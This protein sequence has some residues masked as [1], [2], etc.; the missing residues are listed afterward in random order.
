LIAAMPVLRVWLAL[1][2]LGL[3]GLAVPALAHL[4]PNSEVRLTFARDAVLGEAAIPQGDYAAASGQPVG[5]QP[6]TIAAARRY[7]QPRIGAVSPD[8]A[9]WR[10][11]IDS[12]RFARIA[13]PPDLL[14]RFRLV[15]PAGHSARR[16]VFEWRAVIDSNPSHFALIVLAGDFAAGK[17]DAEPQILGSVQAGERSVA[18]DR[19]DSGLW[20]GFAAAFATGMHHIGNGYDHMLFLLVLL[21]P[22]PV[23]AAAGRWQG[24]RGTMPLA[25]SLL[26][27]VTAF[28]IGHSL[29]LIAAAAFG[30]QLPQRPVEVLIALS[31]AIAALHALRP[32]FPRRE[33]WV[34]GLF[35]LVHGLAF[36]SVIGRIGVGPVEQGLAILGFN[37]GIEAMQLLIVACVLPA[38]LLLAAT[39]YYG[40]LRVGLGVTALLAALAWAVQRAWGLD[41]HVTDAIDAAFAQAPI[42][43]ALLTVLAALAF[44]RSRARAA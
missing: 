29:T 32:L 4:T 5:N 28:T 25:R 18:I 37:L 8:G 2:V 23:I 43:I 11:R 15:P 13:G 39:P 17:L 10:V 22:A 21:L 34:A 7:L 38:L 31:I 30:A 41:S 24:R 19:G 35:G 36:A 12:L 3:A 27:V 33:A 14:V 42:A 20:R 40:G 26:A 9:R 6:A 16:L 44:V 1:L